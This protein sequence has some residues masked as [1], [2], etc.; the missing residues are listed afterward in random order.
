MRFP[1]IRLENFCDGNKWV[2]AYYANHTFEVNFLLSDNSRAI[3]NT[4]DDIY[5]RKAD[6]ERSSKLLKDDDLE[7]LGKEVLRLAEK[8]GKGWFALMVATFLPGKNQ[9]VIP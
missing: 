1:K 2:N 5:T 9:R 4:L 6:I 7:V 3:V 8:V